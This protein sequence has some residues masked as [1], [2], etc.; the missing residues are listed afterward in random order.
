MIFLCLLSI[1]CQLVYAEPEQN[2]LLVAVPDTCVALREGR[3]C[4][5]DVVLNWQ[6]PQLGNYCLRDATSKHIM[7]CWL[8]QQSGQFN[9]AFDST[10]TIVFE[11]INSDNSKVI[12]TTQV[13]L[14][15]VYQNRQKKRR[16]RLF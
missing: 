16:W 6:H 1:K 11:L 7:Q 9:Y 3:K 15:W 10:K 13:Q 2:S 5:T 14:Q 8:R 12:A 4:Y